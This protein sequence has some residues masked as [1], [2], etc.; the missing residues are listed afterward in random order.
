MIPQKI[1]YCWFGRGNKPHLIR[2]CIETWKRVMPDY[3]IKEWNEDNFDIN[4]N[5]FVRKRSEERRV[6]KEC[7]GRCSSR[8]WPYH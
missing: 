3:E 7:K 6:G 4:C 8:G 2:K 1:H 5:E